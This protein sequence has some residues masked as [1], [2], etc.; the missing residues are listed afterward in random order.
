MID[1]DGI[2]CCSRKHSGSS[3]AVIRT[4]SFTQSEPMPARSCN[5]HLPLSRDNLVWLMAS[6]DP[7]L[8]SVVA[9]L[10]VDA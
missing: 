3:I 4:T 2:S 8:V 6:S 5:Y 1:I 9:M 7:I 10:V